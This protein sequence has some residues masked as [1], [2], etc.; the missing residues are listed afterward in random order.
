MKISKLLRFRTSL[1]PVEQ[2]QVV[3]STAVVVTMAT[4]VGIRMFTVG[5]TIDWLLFGSIITTGV[6]GF[7]NVFFT[8]KYGQQ[9]E[10]QKRELLALNTIAEAVNRSVE[11]SLLLQEAIREVRRLL[12]IDFGWIYHVEGGKLALRASDGIAPPPSIII[13]P[14]MDADASELV[15]ARTAHTR[16][17]PHGRTDEATWPFKSIAAWGSVPIVVKDRYAGVIV[18]ASRERSE[19][20][21]KQ[22][23]LMGAFSNQIGVALENA[24][25][26]EQLRKSEE[27]Y[28]DLFEHSPDMSHIVTRE[29]IIVSCNQTEVDRL[30]YQKEELIGYSVL[31]LYPPAYHASARALLN[32]VFQKKLEVSGLEEQFVAQSGEVVDVSIST[33]VVYDELRNPAFMRVVARDVTEK[34][35]LESK[36]LHAQRIDSIGNLAGGVAHDFNNILTSILGSTAIMKRKMRKSNAWYH[37]ADIIET[38]AKRGAGL[39]RQL[40]TFA[41]KSTPQFRPIIVDDIIEET[42]RLFERSIDKS[43]AI[44]KEMSEDMAIIKG[45]DGQIQQAVLNLL[46]NAR[47]AMPDGGTIT[48]SSRAV[49]PD[50][51]HSSV[52]GEP[53]AGEFAAIVIRDTGVGMNQEVQQRIFEPFFTT[54]EKGTGLGLSVVYGVVNSHG[55]FITVQSDPGRGS[56]FSMFFPLLANREK[57]QRTLKQQRL[58]QGHE[59]ILVVDDEEH[60][61]ELISRMLDH[62]GYK[63]MVV[64]T[65]QEALT[66]MKKKEKFDAIILDM[67]MPTMSGK[68]TFLKLK[69]IRPDMR[70]VVSTGY[71]NESLEPTEMSKQVDGFLQKPYQLEE[72]SKVLREVFDGKRDEA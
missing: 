28:M 5:K 26:F 31:T 4:I 19:I 68:E 45:D 29:G 12:D 14:N 70:V 72:L 51:R 39:T 20:T 60:V 25:L 40:L 44:V 27:R 49:T 21:E 34:K 18:V 15:W 59:R 13:E 37:F 2:A 65:G 43:I 6:F 11:I 30:G 17:K 46:I 53:R 10:E 69:E 55:G 33:S 38:A 62:L 35:R 52:F 57:F 23:A 47:D 16:R 24:T 7:I 50:I 67:N 42:L 61:S 54:K 63:S 36:I 41:R 32:E 9:L 3:A 56:Q 48:I 1:G 71:S 64:H 22:L 66:L 8:L 58:R